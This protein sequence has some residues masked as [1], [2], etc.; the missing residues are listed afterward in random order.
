MSIVVIVI[1]AQ[2]LISRS[3]SSSSN[4]GLS[5]GNVPE[6]VGKAKPI[7]FLLQLIVEDITKGECPGSGGGGGRGSWE[8]EAAERAGVVGREPGENALRMVEMRARELLGLGVEEKVVL[9]NG[10]EKDWVRVQH[11]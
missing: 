2:M 1:T 4:H 5:A 10:T 6:S 11:G 8:L 7:L 3:S 9:A